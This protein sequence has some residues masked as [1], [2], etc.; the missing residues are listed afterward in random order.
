MPPLWCGLGSSPSAVPVEAGPA[1]GLGS[2]NVERVLPTTL[3]AS[4]Q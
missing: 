1:P 4:E 2:V 3:L